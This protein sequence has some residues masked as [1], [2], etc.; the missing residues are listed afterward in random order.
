MSRSSNQSQGHNSNKSMSVCPDIGLWTWPKYPEDVPIYQKWSFY[1]KDFESY[2][3][4]RTDRRTDRRDWKYYHAVFAGDN[5]LQLMLLADS[6]RHTNQCRRRWRSFGCFAWRSNCSRHNRQFRSVFRSC[7]HH[8]RRT[9][10]PVI[11]CDLTIPHRMY[12]CRLVHQRS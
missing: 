4:N 7:G 3:P 10:L 2:N 11:P 5:T 8:T 9:L 6:E 12:S 1:A